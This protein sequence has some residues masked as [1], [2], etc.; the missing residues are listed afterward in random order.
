MSGS[1]QSTRK[2]HVSRRGGGLL[3]GLFDGGGL[4]ADIFHCGGVAGGLGQQ[5]FVPALAFANAPRMH[6]GGSSVPWR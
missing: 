2:K 5:R 1:S 4:L 6:S 3:G